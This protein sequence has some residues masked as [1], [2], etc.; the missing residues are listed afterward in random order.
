MGLLSLFLCIR[1]F[2]L[3]FMSFCYFPLFSIRYLLLFS[4]I[5]V[6]QIYF[7]IQGDNESF[8]KAIKSYSTFRRILDV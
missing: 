1:F 4:S 5:T 7:P 6:F 3:L 8:C 2:L